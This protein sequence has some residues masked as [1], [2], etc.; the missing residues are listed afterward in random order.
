MRFFLLILL[1]LSLFLPQPLPAQPADSLAK[2]IE[3]NSQAIDQATKDIQRLK[4]SV[5]KEKVFRNLE[6]NGQSLDAFLQEMR[7]KEEK[8]K[9]QVSI[10]IGLGALFLIVLLVGLARRRKMKG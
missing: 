3:A 4:D 5:E 1:C 9:R 10:R 2:A 7:E 6:Q 8:Q